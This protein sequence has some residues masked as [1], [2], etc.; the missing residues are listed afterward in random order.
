MEVGVDVGMLKLFLVGSIFV[1]RLYKI[2]CPK[3]ISV[4]VSFSL[5]SGCLFSVSG[6]IVQQGGGEQTYFNY[7]NIC[8]E[9]KKSGMASNHLFLHCP[10]LSITAKYSQLC[11]NQC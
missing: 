7:T 3:C 1:A 2:Y 5:E 11:M 10:Y 9:F 4:L 6:V 8:A